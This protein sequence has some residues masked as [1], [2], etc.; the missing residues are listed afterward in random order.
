MMTRT[1]AAFLLACAFWPA[2]AA[3]GPQLDWARHGFQHGAW[4]CYGDCPSG[5][6]RPSSAAARPAPRARA[7]RGLFDGTWAVSA[8]GPCLSA[9]TSQVMISGG[10]IMGQNGGGGHVTPGGVVSTVGNVDGVTVVGEGQ[11][12]G[13]SG[14]GIYTQSDGCSSSWNAVKL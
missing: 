4:D 6:L 14:S 5:R 3:A 13:R 12:S 7:N 10:R 2:A 11:I 1:I 8:S 9:G